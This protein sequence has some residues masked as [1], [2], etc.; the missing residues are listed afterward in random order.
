MASVH[1]SMQ[2]VLRNAN[3]RV[4]VHT[5]ANTVPQVRAWYESS[6]WHTLKIVELAIPRFKYMALVHA[7]L[8]TPLQI[9]SNASVAQ[10]TVSCSSRSNCFC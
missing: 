5:F 4:Q 10:G 6:L 1:V 8:C 7:H 2:S 3:G 9:T